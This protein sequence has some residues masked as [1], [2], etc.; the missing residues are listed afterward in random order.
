MI[1][2]LPFYQK[3]FDRFSEELKKTSQLVER[4]SVIRILVFIAGLILLYF[5][6]TFSL[7]IALAYSACFAIVFGFI[8]YHHGI[9]HKLKKNL[10]ILKDINKNEIAA[11][12]GEFGHFNKGEEFISN[13]NH[14]ADDLDIFGTGSLFQYLDRSTTFSGKEKLAHWLA[15]QEL[16]TEQILLKQE[17]VKELADKPEWRQNLQLIGKNT[18]EKKQDV[19]DILKWLEEEP[20]IKNKKFIY[21]IILVNLITFTLLTLSILAIIP[22]VIFILHIMI[23]PFLIIGPFV[24]R[25]NLIHAQLGKKTDLLLKYS[26]IIKLIEGEKFTSNYLFNLKKNSAIIDNNA[27]RIIKNLSKIS[28][29]FNQRLNMI[30]G[31]LLNIFLLW[32]LIQT[33]RLENWKKR[34]KEQLV[35]WFDVIGEFD[36]LSSLACFAFNN[37]GY[38]IPKI[39]EKKFLIQA[40]EMGH[41]LIHHKNRINNSIAISGQ[42]QFVIITGANMAGKST[43]LRTLG[44]NM[45]LASVGAPVCAQA[46]EWSP[47]QIFTSIR[48]KDS[49]YKN[50]SYFFAELKQ[51]KVLIDQLQSGKRLFII[52][53]EILKGTNSKDKQTGSMHLIEQLIRL[54]SSGIIATHDLALGDLVKTYP[55]NI[56]NMRFEVEFNNDELVFDYKLKS[57]ISQNMNA[58]FL[59]KK[60]GITV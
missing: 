58:T 9:L 2:P 10:T 36:A 14:Y 33:I 41:P 40:E 17:A 21:F 13:E 8:V 60:M 49:L 59:M 51:L 1:P 27:S 31:V 3:R 57:G 12:N 53:D 42:Q 4:Y 37:P 25:I 29:A 38:Q 5:S 46:F 32:D 15:N 20:L 34:H 22:S 56:S 54:N 35:K 11:I 7:N 55:N 23:I 26:T 19:L 16:N 18:D 45:I 44:V 39:S 48:T 28:S 52:L 43:F 50:E 24:K 47:I 6:T 30:A